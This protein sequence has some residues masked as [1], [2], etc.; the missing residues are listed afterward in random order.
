MEHLYTLF[1]LW[2]FKDDKFSCA[3]ASAL[4]DFAYLSYH[5]ELTI[6]R[7]MRDNK[8]STF[9]QFEDA[10]ACVI[11]DITIISFS[12]LKYKHKKDVMENYTDT[13]QSD[14]YDGKIHTKFKE[15]FTQ[16]YPER[17]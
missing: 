15:Q 16:L 14:S 12:G 2:P 7:F 4:V 10:I 13:E 3:K 6:R 9:K 8:I 5:G 17:K 11:E 1:H